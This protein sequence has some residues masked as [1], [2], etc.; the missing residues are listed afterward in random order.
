MSRMN[1]VRSERCTLLQGFLSGFTKKLKS[2]ADNIQFAHGLNFTSTPPNGYYPLFIHLPP[3]SHVS[4]A[5]CLLQLSTY[6]RNFH[7]RASGGMEANCEGSSWQ[8]WCFLLSNLACWSTL[9]LWYVQTVH[10][11]GSTLLLSSFLLMVKRGRYVDE[12][13]SWHKNLSLSLS[14]SLS[15]GVYSLVVVIELK[16]W[17]LQNYLNREKN[18]WY[19]RGFSLSTK[20]VINGNYSMWIAPVKCW[21][22]I[23][24]MVK[25]QY[26]QQRRQQV[27]WFSSQTGLDLCLTL[28]R[29]PWR[30]KKSQRLWKT[31]VLLLATV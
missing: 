30:Q 16:V 21:Q 13:H 5:G 25:H 20:G 10:P 31:F 2:L 14:L 28:L 8:G 19:V 18:W 26:H 22:H 15:L 17:H 1:T 11:P 9:S 23:N 4:F 7:R 6:S 12:R 29:V 27:V 3:V 24:L